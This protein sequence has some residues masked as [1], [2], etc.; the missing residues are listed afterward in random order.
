MAEFAKK[1]HNIDT[2]DTIDD[3][4]GRPGDNSLPLI[5]AHAIGDLQLRM[6]AT[7]ASLLLQDTRDAPPYALAVRQMYVDD[8]E[9][10]GRRIRAG[11]AIYPEQ[12]S[13]GTVCMF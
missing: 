11:V 6:L 9:A 3:E 4:V 7:A 5:V 1:T 13:F 12:P 2:D 10:R 8:S